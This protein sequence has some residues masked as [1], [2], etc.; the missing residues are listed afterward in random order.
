MGK[1]CYLL[2]IFDHKKKKREKRGISATHCESVLGLLNV[3]CNYGEKAQI[4]PQK[5][6]VFYSSLP[7]NLIILV[8]IL[9]VENL[10]HILSFFIQPFFFLHFPSGMQSTNTDF[11][12][13][14]KSDY[15]D[16]KD[17][18]FTGSNMEKARGKKVSYSSVITEAF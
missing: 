16:N 14:L 6:R 17:F 5:K 11:Q 1:F 18:F 12:H 7:K 2:V 4:H 3:A 9:S 10:C 8:E 15:K 13:V